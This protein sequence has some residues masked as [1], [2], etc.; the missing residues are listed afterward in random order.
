MTSSFGVVVS[1]PGELTWEGRPVLVHEPAQG[2][3]RSA[4]AGLEA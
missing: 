2:M 3:H 1:S 4:A